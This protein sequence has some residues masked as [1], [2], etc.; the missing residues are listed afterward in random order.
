MA[1]VVEVRVVGLRGEHPSWGPTRIRYQLGK[2]G[3]DP[4]PGRSS[5]YRA[6]V[7]YGLIDPVKRKRKR[8][9]STL[10]TIPGYAA[11]ADG[12]DGRSPAG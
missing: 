2:E 8:R 5:V 12:R 10:G 6:L 4:L 11:V 7:R 9:S 1:P 3:V